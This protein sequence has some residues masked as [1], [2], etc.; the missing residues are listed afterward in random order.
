MPKRGIQF[1]PSDQILRYEE[2]LRLTDI[3]IQ[4]GIKKLRITGGEPLIRRNVLF[5]CRELGKRQALREIALTTNGTMLA[6]YAEDLFNAGIKRI[7]VSLDTLN[8][9]NYRRITGVDQIDTV[10]EGIKILQHLGITVKL[11]V[12][13][14]KGIN[15]GEFMD[16]IHFSQQNNIEVRFIEIMPHMYSNTFTQNVF[17]STESIMQIIGRRY[18]LLP[19]SSNADNATARVYKLKHSDVKVGFISAVSRPFCSSCNKLRLMADGTL[20]S[21]LFSESGKNLKILLSQGYTDSE[22]INEIL[23]ELSEKP[24]HHELNKDNRNLVMH[25]V[26]G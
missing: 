25:R 19:V 15:E 6:Q 2:I 14:M 24:Q 4:M 11:N 9:A 5:L 7:N 8:R 20:R 10:F 1:L 12:V 17:I 21:C 3:F 23:T 18:A 22:I 13:A 26:G 16:F